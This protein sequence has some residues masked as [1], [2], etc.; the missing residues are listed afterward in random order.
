MNMNKLMNALRTA[1]SGLAHLAQQAT[2]SLAHRNLPPLGQVVTAVSYQT[3][4][5]LAG[6]G[7]LAQLGPLGS[8][9]NG[10]SFIVNR[11]MGGR[12]PIKVELLVVDDLTRSAV[13][14]AQ[15]IGQ[16]TRLCFDDLQKAIG[17]LSFGY[18][19]SR[20]REQGEADELR[21]TLG[22]AD[23]VL[24][25]Q[26]L[27][28]RDGGG[29]AAE[30]F[31]DTLVDCLNTYPFT[32]AA[33]V[34]RAVLLLCTDYTKPTAA[35]LSPLQV[36]QLFAQHRTHLFVVGEPG[37]NTAEM[38]QGAGA[39]GGGFIE[40]TANPGPQELAV[41]ATRL[42]GTLVGTLSTAGT[43]TVPGRPLY[44]TGLTVPT[45]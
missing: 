15:V 4:A 34:V 16:I 13:N 43:G 25:E 5:A 29:D 35:G 37:S 38:V 14:R 6:P 40:L 33:D 41:V 44:P 42:T 30:T 22:T 7:G 8:L 11:A 20:D 19:G 2:Q 32:H 17:D 18:V 3:Q 45:P 23:Q 26:Q 24:R 1:R 12:K 31:A 27:V 28:I 10:P 36:G 9:G 39:F 21:V